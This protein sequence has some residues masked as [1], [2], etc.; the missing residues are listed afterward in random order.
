MSE[1]KEYDWINKENQ[2]TEEGEYLVEAPN[3]LGGVSV[4]IDEWKDSNF[5]NSYRTVLRY[6]KCLS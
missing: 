3:P 5:V 4:Y 2:P 1:F 6:K